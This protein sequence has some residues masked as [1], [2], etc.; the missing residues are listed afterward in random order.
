MET[1]LFLVGVYMVPTIVALARN[2][3]QA[4]RVPNIG[5]LVVI[6]VLLGWTFVGWVVALAM[7]CQAKRPVTADL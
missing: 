4:K 5:P 3:G 6:N 7:A 2:D 1:A